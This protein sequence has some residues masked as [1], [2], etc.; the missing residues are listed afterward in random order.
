MNVVKLKDKIKPGDDFF[1]NYLKGK[2]AWWVHMRYI[3][4]FECMGVQGY[5]AC[6]ENINDLFKPPYGTEFRD[7]YCKDMWPYIDQDATDAANCVNVFKMQNKYSAD[8]DI[9]ADE[10][11]LFRTW[12]ATELLKFDQNNKEEQL[13]SI[14]TPK[15]TSVLMYYKN[16]MYDEVIK[17]LNEFSSNTIIQNVETKPCTCG[18]YSDL[19]ALYTTASI[20]DPISIY[21][22]NI[23]NAM[24]DMFSNIEFWTQFNREF[25]NEMKKY[26][27]NIINMN[28]SLN[29]V[30]EVNLY[31]DCTCLNSS[32]N[33]NQEILKRLSQSLQYMISNQVAGHKN[34][35]ADA[36]YDWS[37]KLYE[38]MQW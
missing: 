19:T 5:I 10:V 32:E 16:N 22:K 15:Q 36:L 26:I 11:K 28:L 12:L 18:S 14:Y 27:D 35:I 6:E 23:Y 20:C 21:R 31:A 37:A 3:I 1:N 25:L 8:S 2:Y 7:T 30:E 17:K 13:N 33:S 38:I 24:V 4:P 29:N 34:F 9:T